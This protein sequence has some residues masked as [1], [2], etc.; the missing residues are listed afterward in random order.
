MKPTK[1]KY[2]VTKAT[3]FEPASYRLMK[4]ISLPSLLWKTIAD[5]AKR[6][7][8][9]VVRQIEAIIS[10]YFNFSYERKDDSWRPLVPQEEIGERK[11]FDSKP[12]VRNVYLPKPLWDL[13]AED[14]K[15]E[16]RSLAGHLEVILSSYYGGG[17][18]G[19]DR[20]LLRF[21][22]VRISTPEPLPATPPKQKAG[23]T[24]K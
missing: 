18:K 8:R 22:K 11:V 4:N 16:R 12:L 5:D 17:P 14:A 7:G 24:R 6:S 2:L 15:P 19:V 9:S 21:L 13:L 20:D 1:Q 3:T 23:K 10:A